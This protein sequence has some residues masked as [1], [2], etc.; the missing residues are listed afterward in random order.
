MHDVGLGG[1]EW[2]DAN[3][4][5]NSVFVFLRKGDGRRRGRLC[6]VQL[7]AGAAQRLPRRRARWAGAGARS[8]NSDAQPFG[9]SGMG[10]LGGVTADAVTVPR[11]PRVAAR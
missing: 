3:D 11:P 5:E 2:V 6:R 4:D 9:G 7:H 8:S 1:F 10:N